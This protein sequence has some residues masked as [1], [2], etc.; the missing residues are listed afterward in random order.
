MSESFMDA[1]QDGFAP[2]DDTFAALKSLPGIDDDLEERM[3]ASEQMEREHIAGLAMVREVAAMTQDD[4]ARKMGVAQGS[5]SRLERRG[6]LLLS[7]LRAYFKA[8]G[9]EATIVLKI[10]DT[11]R[12]V[13]LDDLVEPRHPSGSH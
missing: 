11:R 12:V 1:Q 4:V 9:A 3:E 13:P 6:D 10:G 7:S 8:V 5:V 2:I